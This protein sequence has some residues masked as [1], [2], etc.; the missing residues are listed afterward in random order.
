[1]DDGAGP[2]F[3]LVCQT[4][5]NTVN[6]MLSAKD[7]QILSE[8]YRDYPLQRVLDAIAETARCKGRSASY[9]RSVIQNDDQQKKERPPTTGPD[10]T[11]PNR[12]KNFGK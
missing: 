11:D 2:D 10:L 8:L 7:G 4:Y 3:G 6:P 9:V 12:Y 1:M 5:E